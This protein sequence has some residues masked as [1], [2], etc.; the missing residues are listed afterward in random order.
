[1]EGG[2][3]YMLSPEVLN[4]KI[5]TV[6]TLTPGIAQPRAP[7]AQWFQAQRRR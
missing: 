1:M 3:G 2:F 6:L 4:L 7:R 5:E